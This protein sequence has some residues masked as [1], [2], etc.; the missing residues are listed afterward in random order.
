MLAPDS[1]HIASMSRE[2]E[3]TK[4]RRCPLEPKSDAITVNNE[5]ILPQTN[6]SNKWHC[7][8]AA[9]V[10]PF[11]PQFLPSSLIDRRA[12]SVSPVESCCQE[13]DCQA[14]HS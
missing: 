10:L 12:A 14:Q 11:D 9:T 3:Q 7:I 5:F 6:L 1:A 8:F 4:N 13:Q 2:N